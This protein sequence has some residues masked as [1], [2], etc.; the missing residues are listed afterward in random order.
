MGGGGDERNLAAS[1]GGGGGVIKIMVSYFHKSTP[2]I[3]I[4]NDD[5]LKWYSLIPIDKILSLEHMP[6]LSL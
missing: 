5:T 3:S 2:S 6:Y 1:D 4:N